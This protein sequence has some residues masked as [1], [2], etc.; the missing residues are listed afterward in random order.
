MSSAS[1]DSFFFF[2]EAESFLFDII[3]N[4]SMWKS[5]GF[6]ETLWLNISENYGETLLKFKSKVSSLVVS[7]MVLFSEKNVLF[8][9]GTKCKI[10]FFNLEK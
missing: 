8:Y 3:L 2:W 4:I 5:F 7:N 6:S 10:D 1:K 9:S